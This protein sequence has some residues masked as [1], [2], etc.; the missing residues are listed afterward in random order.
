MGEQK[1]FNAQLSQKI[2]TVE[3]SMDQR[4]DGFQSEMDEKIDNLHYPIS[5]LTNQLVH[6]EEENPEEVCMTDTILGEEAPLQLQLQKGL[7]EEPAE[8]PP[9]ELQDVP[10]LGVVYGPWKKE[11][12][13]TALLTEEGSGKE[14]GEEPQKLILYLNPIN[15]DPFST[16]QATKCP[17]PIAP[18]TDQV[19]IL[20]SPA[21]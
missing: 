1:K 5:K 7:E 15:L 21:P 18:S 6:Q 9:Q 4:L 8:A 12:A 16:A 2:H 19:Y 17:L 11:E 20:P 3:N 10:Q 13:I 14:E